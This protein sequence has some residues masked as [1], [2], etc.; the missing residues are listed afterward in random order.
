MPSG[1]LCETR[2]CIALSQPTHEE[3]KNCRLI[4]VHY[5]NTENRRVACTVG[6]GVRTT[7]STTVVSVYK[8]QVQ[9]TAVDAL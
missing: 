1:H 6:G 8:T 2:V 9:T 7:R 5:F 3:E 4:P